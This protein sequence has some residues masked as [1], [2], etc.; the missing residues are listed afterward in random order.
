MNE[1]P[2]DWGVPKLEVNIQAS[3]RHRGEQRAT[4][5][6]MQWFDAPGSCVQVQLK[7]ASLHHSEVRTDYSGTR[8]RED[9]TFRASYYAWIDH[10]WQLH[11]IPQER[12]YWSCRKCG[13][14]KEAA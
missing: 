10:S 5:I 2:P 4:E 9:Y 6:A 11:R 14:E 3:S 8:A 13:T 12:N 7:E 1:D